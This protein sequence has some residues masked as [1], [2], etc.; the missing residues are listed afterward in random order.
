MA[1]MVDR[2][3]EAMKKPNNQDVVVSLLE[4]IS[5]YYTSIIPETFA[6]EDIATICVEADELCGSQNTSV[7]EVLAALEGAAGI[8]AD[9]AKR[10][11]SAMTVLACLS[12]K[13]VNP[14]FARTDAI[15][16]VMRK[17][18]KPVTDPV[19]EQLAILRG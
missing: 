13:L 10:Y 5:G 4:A 17:K 12:V 7:C 6:Q 2:V 16:T 15:G 14:I 3:M 19:F 8:D 1:K 11:L 18:I 9:K